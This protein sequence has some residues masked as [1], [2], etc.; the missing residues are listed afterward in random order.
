MNPEVAQALRNVG[1]ENVLEQQIF[2][3]LNKLKDYRFTKVSFPEEVKSS[4][5]RYMLRRPNEVESLIE[6]S[7]IR[8]D[9]VGI[10]NEGVHALSVTVDV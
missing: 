6:L 3:T 2:D 1:M 9:F 5:D 7:I 4:F 8:A 10:A